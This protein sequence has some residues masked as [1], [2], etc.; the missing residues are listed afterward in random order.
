MADGEK[1]SHRLWQTSASFLL[2]R[3][4]ERSGVTVGDLT[5]GAAQVA[6]SVAVAVADPNT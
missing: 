3:T 1:S 6:E 4:R 5:V 2:A